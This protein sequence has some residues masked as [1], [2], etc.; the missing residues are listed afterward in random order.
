MTEIELVCFR[1]G[2]EDI[3]YFGFLEVAATI[4]LSAKEGLTACLALWYLH[5]LAK[6]EPL[7]GQLGW[8]V[9]VGP[10]ADLTR[11]KVLEKKDAWIREPQVGEKRGAKRMRGWVMPSDPLNRKMEG[12]RKNARALR[13][14]RNN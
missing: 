5:M 6:D 12:G 7:P 2:T 11:S 14:V 4:E 13:E 1:L 8:K 3:P 10:P 9:E